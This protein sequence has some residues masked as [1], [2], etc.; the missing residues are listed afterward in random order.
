MNR[1]SCSELTVFTTEAE[2]GSRITDVSMTHW[3]VLAS[4][5]RNERSLGRTMENA[6]QINVSARTSAFHRFT[7][8]THNFAPHY[9]L[10]KGVVG[11]WHRPVHS[12]LV[13]SHLNTVFLFHFVIGYDERVSL[14]FGSPGIH[15]IDIPMVVKGIVYYLK[16]TGTPSHYEYYVPYRPKIKIQKG[17]FYLVKT[18]SSQSANDLMI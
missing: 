12:A 13:H 8:C 15:A 14:S 7:N 4:I 16:A 10:S 11:W 1:W 5:I 2:W 3:R 6:L 18:R 17:M 9:P